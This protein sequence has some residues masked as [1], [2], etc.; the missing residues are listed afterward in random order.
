MKYFCK[1]VV[2]SGMLFIPFAILKGCGGGGNPVAAGSGKHAPATVNDVIVTESEVRSEAADR[3]ESIELRKLRNE[4]AYARAEHEAMMEALE[5]VLED[6]LLTLEA[7]ERNISKEQLIDHEI[8]QKITEPSEEEIDRVY[9][10]N[11]ARVNRP[12]EEV[13]DQ[14]R[15]F[16]RDMDEKEIREAFLKQLEQKHTV[17]RNLGPFRFDVKTDDRP[18]IGPND[19][20][21]KLVLFSDFQCP[22]CRVFGDTLVKIAGDY[23]DQVQLVFRQFPLTHIHVNAQYAAEASLCAHDQKRFW[24]VHDFMFENQRELTEENILKAIR[25]LGL[26]TEIFNEC[27]A[28]GRHKTTVREDVRAAAAAGVDS[29]P[30][31]FINGLYLS[32]NQ[33]YGTV[34]AII[35]MELAKP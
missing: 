11:R 12:K 24:E 16:L 27:I 10:L 22:F 14:I 3:L 29:T 1:L 20:P 35:D 7:A 6:R 5:R 34:A 26:D 13:E 19:A 32:G 18:S 9:E 30:A 21:I 23:G 33:P 15:E 28:S 2:F 25:F 31:L 8:R 17:V 4:A